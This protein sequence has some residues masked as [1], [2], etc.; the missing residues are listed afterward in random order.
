MKDG[1][2]AIGESNAILRYLALKYKSEYYP[3]SDPALCAVIDFAMDSFANEVY[4][5]HHDTVYVVF[6]FASAPKDQEAANKQYSE[7]LDTW[8]A[9]FLKGKFVCGEKL[10]IADFK[11]VP[12]LIAAMQP[13]VEAKIGLTV[14]DRIKQY[15]NDFCAA[16]PSSEMLKAAGGYSIVEFLAS[17]A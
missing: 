17:K 10:S 1:G 7:S 2:L 14:P 12:F 4:K 13:V 15:V 8:A 9:L 11:A 3:T 6:G 5:A 16:V